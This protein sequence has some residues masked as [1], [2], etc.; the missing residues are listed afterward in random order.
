MSK[1]PQVTITGGPHGKDTELTID[2]VRAKGAHRVE[3]VWDVKDAV[4][5]TVHSLVTAR[6]DGEAVVRY[7]VMIRDDKV[8]E[9]EGKTIVEDLGVYGEGFTLVEAL[10]DLTAKLEV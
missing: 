10:K 3:A 1:F 6:F 5:L 2:G 9:E 8:T 7:R 4:R